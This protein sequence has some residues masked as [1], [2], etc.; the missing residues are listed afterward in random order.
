MESCWSGGSSARGSQQSGAGIGQCDG[1]EDDDHD[2]HDDDDDDDDDDYYYDKN[3]DTELT[4]HC[5][6]EQTL[7]HWEPWLQASGD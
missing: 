5:T 7:L 6:G 1:D 2:D 4:L 3:T